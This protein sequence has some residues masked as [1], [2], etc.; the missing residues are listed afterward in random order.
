MKKT[1]LIFVMLTLFLASAI[2]AQQGTNVPSEMYYV[3]LTIEK[4]YPYHL[5]YIVVYRSGLFQTY[6]TYI[7]R[8]WFQGVANRGEVVNLRRG[9][10]EWPSM[11]VYYSRGEFSHV[12]LRLRDRSHQTWGLVR[13]GVNMDEYF[14][15]IDELRLE[16]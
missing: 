2:F 14:D 9:S 6:Q 5:G 11:T 7:P 12:K 3:N 16:F 13:P 1:I 10:R 15:N 8:E 4:I